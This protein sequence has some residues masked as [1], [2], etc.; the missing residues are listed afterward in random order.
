MTRFLDSVYRLAVRRWYVFLAVAATL[1]LIMR[2]HWSLRVLTAVLFGLVAGIALL[3]AGHALYSVLVPGAEKLKFVPRLDDALADARRANQELE[4][5][6]YSLSRKLD[7]LV[8]IRDSSDQGG[9]GQLWGESMRLYQQVSQELAMRQQMVEFYKSS[10]VR[11][12]Q[13]EKEQSEQQRLRTIERDLDQL[14]PRRS[15]GRG[16][17]TGKALPA[18]SDHVLQSY[19]DLSEQLQRVTTAEAASLIKERWDEL[20]RNS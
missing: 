2:F 18:P 10:L 16:R 20:L 19:S 3:G 1:L 11:F 8:K 12:R 4:S 6:L 9:R 7:A 17:K 14:N 15:T 13:Y 5:Q